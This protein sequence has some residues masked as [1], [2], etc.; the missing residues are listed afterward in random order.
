MR[1]VFLATVV[2]FSVGFVASTPAEAAIMGGAA[3]AAAPWNPV[4]LARCVQRSVGR[5]LTTH[6]GE[7]LTPPASQSH[8]WRHGRI[9]R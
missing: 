4:E 9:R 8:R 7:C 6:V 5:N 2:A 1:A 3:I